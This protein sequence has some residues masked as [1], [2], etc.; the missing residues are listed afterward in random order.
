M[1]EREIS[2]TR[3]DTYVI[4]FTITGLNEELDTAYFTCRKDKLRETPIVFQLSLNDGINYL[5]DNHYQ[6]EIASEL[7]QNLDTGSYYYDL[8]LSKNGSVLTPL[9]GKLKLTW[10][11]TGGEDEDE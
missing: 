6:V 10:D 11:V 1:Q 4:G 8:E 7:T 2:F 5:G 3:G 9:K